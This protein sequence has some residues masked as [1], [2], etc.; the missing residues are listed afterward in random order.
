MS[1][2]E[3]DDLFKEASA[4]YEAPFEEKEWE[5]MAALLDKSPSPKPGFWNWKIRS[6]LALLLFMSGTVLITQWDKVDG[7]VEKKGKASELRSTDGVSSA[8]ATEQTESKEHAS[9]KDTATER[10]IED[11]HA[12]GRSPVVREQEPVSSPLADASVS[13]LVRTKGNPVNENMEQRKAKTTD[14]NGE[15]ALKESVAER[16]QQNN[17]SRENASTKDHLNKKNKG[18]EQL[19]TATKSAFGKKRTIQKLPALVAQQPNGKVSTSAKESAV[20]S[21]EQSGDISTTSK[22]EKEMLPPD[23]M[24]SGVKDEVTNEKGS[25]SL[26]AGSKPMAVTNVSEEQ[27]ERLSASAIPPGSTATSKNNSVALLSSDSSLV[28]T[29]SIREDSVIHEAAAKKKERKRNDSTKTDRFSVKLA[30]SPDFS[31]IGYF[32][33]GKTG[34]NYGLLAEYAITRHW[35]ITLGGIWSKKSYAD[36]ET[37]N[38]GYGTVNSTRIDGSCRVLDLPLNMTYYFRPQNAFSL[39]GSV[40]LSSYFMF[41]EDYTYDYVYGTKQYSYS[42]KIDR[43]NTEWFRMMNLSVGIQQ[44]LSARVRLQLEP[45]IKAPL[46]G[47]GGGD[48]KLVSSGVFFNVKYTFK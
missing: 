34:F 41:D 1:D 28:A 14:E 43:G 11:N 35:S 38:L 18:Q 29:S 46:S 27:K 19:S 44:Q 23:E 3:L 22:N 7:S 2:Q 47:I 12:I 13:P 36:T 42:K 24:V 40:G 26:L 33:P 48:L 37:E 31:S 16:T 4:R 32:K 6:G 21:G 15:T 9:S 8:K 25:A 30:L 20:S 39:Y 17:S 10:T 45:F 5:K